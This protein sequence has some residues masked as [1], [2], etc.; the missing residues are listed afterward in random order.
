MQVNG[1]GNLGGIPPPHGIY[2]DSEEGEEEEVDLGTGFMDP[3]PRWPQG[4][5]RLKFAL[6]GKGRKSGKGFQPL[7]NQDQS[8]D[9][10]QAEMEAEEDPDLQ[11]N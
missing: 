10:G 7:H 1:E 3:Q 9:H 8:L 6:G 11:I 4:R 2:G 5:N